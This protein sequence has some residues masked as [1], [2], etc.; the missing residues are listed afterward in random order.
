MLLLRKNVNHSLN[1]IELEISCGYIDG[2]DPKT[3]PRSKTQEKSDRCEPWAA[4]LSFRKP[5]LCVSRLPCVQISAFNLGVSSSESLNLYA[6]WL[7]M[8]LELSGTAISYTGWYNPS[9][10]LF[11]HVWIIN[12]PCKSE[13]K[14]TVTHRSMSSN[15]VQLNSSKYL[16]DRK[17]LRDY[18]SEICTVP[19]SLNGF[20][21]GTGSPCS[22]LSSD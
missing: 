17:G 21:C 5:Y 7:L 2:A 19:M 11:F 9:Q 3:H 16:Y 13:L 18:T 15:L 22:Q 20:S 14:I 6:T 1:L 4:A 10:F 8:T 12:Q